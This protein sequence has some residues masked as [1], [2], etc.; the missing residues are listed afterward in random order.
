MDFV[1]SLL[2]PTNSKRE[3]YDSILVIVDGFMKMIQYE[4]LEITFDT[5]GL[6]E[7]IIDIVVEH[8]SRPDLIMTDS[9]LLFTSKFWQLLRY[10]LGINRRL[11]TAFHPK[12]YS[13][14]AQQNSKI[15]VSIRGFVNFEQNN[16]ARL[17]LITKFANNN[18]KNTS[19]GYTLFELNYGYHL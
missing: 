12:T 4:S 6:A 5:F 7:I 2:I 11:S 14:I 18:T 1:T 9:G 8:P 19:T 3:F 13:Q 17:L 10:L 15:E 16:W